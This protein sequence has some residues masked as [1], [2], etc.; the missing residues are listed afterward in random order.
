M[1]LVI[2]SYAEEFWVVRRLSMS[3]FSLIIRVNSFYPPSLKTADL[4][5]GFSIDRLSLG[6]VP[7]KVN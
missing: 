1:V 3:S 4:V 7:K 6:K 5:P 2:L